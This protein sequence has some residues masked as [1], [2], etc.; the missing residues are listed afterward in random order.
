MTYYIAEI[1]FN[2]KSAKQKREKKMRRILNLTVL[3]LVFT[4]TLFFLA[5]LPARSPHNTSNPSTTQILQSNE[6]L[7]LRGNVT[8]LPED[9]FKNNASWKGQKNALENKLN[10]VENQ[11]EAGAFN[12]SLNKLKN[13]MKKHISEWIDPTYAADLIA[14]VDEIIDLIKGVTPPT[15]DFSIEASPDSLAIEQGGMD[16]ST[17]TI[18]SLNGFSQSVDLDVTS[19]PISGVTT[20]LDPLQVTPPPDG[21]INS[22]LTVEVASTVVPATYTITVTGTNNS[23]A[24]STDISL[25]VTPTPPVP[26]FSINAYPTSLTIHQGGSNTSIITVTSLEGFNQPVDLA[27]TSEPITG[28]TVTLN[29]SQ[30]IPPPNKFAISILTVNVASAVTVGSYSITVKGT[31]D[32]LQHSVDILLEVT[33][34]PVPSYP[35]FSMAAFP[36]SL[37]IQTGDSAT[38]TIVVISLRDFSEPVDLTVTSEPIPDVTVTVDPSMVTPPP[39]GFAT[40][41]LTVDVD[42]MALPGEYGITVVGTSGALEHSVDISLKIAVEDTPP[43]IVSVFRIPEEPSY[44]DSVTVLAAVTDADSGVKDV[45]IGYSSGGEWKNVTMALKEEG[46]YKASIPAFS[47]GTL[48]E[49]R[50]YALDNAGN[51]ASSSVYSYVVAD[52][53][54]PHIGVLSWW[55]EEPDAN[56]DV[57]VNV[58]VTEPLDGSGVK[59]VTLWYN[60]TGE[61]QS[62]EMTLANENW[63]ATIPGQS[64]DATVVFHV[65]AYDKAGNSEMTT[66]YEYTVKPAPWPLAWL[67]GIAL[68]VAALTGTGIYAFYRR[69]KTRSAEGTTKPEN[70]PVVSF[71]VPA[72]ILT[73]DEQTPERDG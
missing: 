55:P 52:P 50:V 4:L 21:S 12:G 18:E 20:T 73:R 39:S 31:S 54:R 14:L 16:T 47:F 10:A 35:D 60:V 24:H 49:Y 40:S 26:D 32:S 64:G 48:V 51:R 38:S 65:E 72:K 29:P 53:Y 69:R 61:W 17:I 41:T 5:V 43:E 8:A 1:R 28:V 45:L 59:N 3:A 37:T 57:I 15:P 9:A 6:W 30:V 71:Y 36:T 22:T 66:M 70:K 7:W 67:A 27:V 2:R 11:I 63:T 34:P 23:L 42:V 56:V 46:L 13:D 62:L 58:T 33:A 25:V 19:P 68:G 44:N